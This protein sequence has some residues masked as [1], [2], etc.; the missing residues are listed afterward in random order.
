MV[1]LIECSHS[2]LKEL[3]VV[4]IDSRHSLVILVDSSHSRVILVDSSYSHLKE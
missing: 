2:H 1:T 3:M 4:L